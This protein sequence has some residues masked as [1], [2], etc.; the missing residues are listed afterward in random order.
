MK[1][2]DIF[3]KVVFIGPDISGSG[4]IASVLGLYSESFK[5]F[6]YLPTNSRSGKLRGSFN[7]ILSLMR[8]PVER[9][10]GRKIAHIHYAGGKS[11]TRKLLFLKF[12]KLLGY[13][14]VMH[15]HCEFGVMS[16]KL[17]ANVVSKNLK[18]ANA[19][20][21]LAKSFKVFAENSLDLRDAKVLNNPIKI[22]DKK[23]E[24]SLDSP[25]I[26]LFLGLLNKDKGCYDIVEAAKILK[27]KN[28]AFKVVL[29][30]TGKS[31]D[32][33]KAMV[34]N[35]Q[36]DSTIL[37]PGWIKDSE[38]TSYL[39]QSH[40]LIL[41]SRSEGMPVSILESKNY[42]LPV[43]ASNVGAIPDI[44]ADGEN[45]FIIEP[46]DVDS[47]AQK[48]QM[49]IENPKLLQNHS[50]SSRDSVK[51]FALSKVANDLQ[52]IYLSLL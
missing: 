5:P 34:K 10:K 52:H 17:G 9:L 46:G 51:E 31:G 29:A 19:N 4:G 8:L 13:K 21:V 42:G 7:T 6:H 33:L 20:I 18:K 38:K 30:G 27:D 32:E 11:W 50:E 26:F 28:L 39:E 14:T 43:I 47:L 40:V 25:V 16:D 37:F 22:Q 44:V 49:Y 12:A 48:M 23:E 24:K 1:E 3:D 35:Y 36:L 45:G 41:P 15:C 2:V